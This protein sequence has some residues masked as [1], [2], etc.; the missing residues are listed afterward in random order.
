MKKLFVF[1][2]ILSL[3]LLGACSNSDTPDTGEEKLRVALVVNQRFGDNGPMDDLSKEADRA[4]KDFGV[5]VRKLESASI[6][7]HEEDV[8][9]MAKEGYDLIITTFPY[10]TE[11]TKLIAQ[12][13]PDTK[14]AAI[15]QFINDDTTSIPNIWD[16]EFHGE[17]AFYVSGFM[18]AKLSESG[19]IGLLIGGEEPSPNA[20]GN[21]FMQAVY[22]VNPNAKVEFSFVGSY[23]DP[24]KAKEIASAMV[25]N[26]VDVLVTNAASSNTGVIEV[27]KEKELICSG[28]ITDY[29][30]E[31]DGFYG[32]VGIGFG[33][34]LY[35]AVEML[36]NDT[37]EG[38]KHGI[39]SLD[40]GGYFLPWEQYTRF[41]EDSEKAK[42]DMPEIIAEA[43][44]L[45]AKLVN[46]ELKVDFDTEVPNWDRIKELN[47]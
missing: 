43:K 38:G 15:F 47:K 23:E 3:F 13:Y 31:Y 32:T 39:R 2:T 22:S 27:C 37:F 7:Q 33:Q 42:D 9:A 18:A 25:S 41:A 12:E 29:Y 46:G 21:G 36:V 14:F 10:M 45:E 16:T 40:N 1:L 11:A 34:T 20:E 35:T 8:R 30:D 28:E 17:Q 6:A 24:A 44:A 26:G 5:E 19:K 4:A